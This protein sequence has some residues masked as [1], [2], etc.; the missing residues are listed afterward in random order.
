MV[1]E[2]KSEKHR[3]IKDGKVN[4]EDGTFKSSVDK[5][6]SQEDLAEWAKAANALPGDLILVLSGEI[7]K[8]RKQLKKTMVFRN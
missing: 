3:K 6:Y 5:F 4:N 8:T 7:E 1:Y 2:T